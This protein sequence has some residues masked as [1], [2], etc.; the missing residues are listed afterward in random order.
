M[1]DK[2]SAEK[3]LERPLSSDN[4]LTQGGRVEELDHIRRE[5]RRTS[6]NRIESQRLRTPST[7]IIDKYLEPVEYTKLPTSRSIRLLEILPVADGVALPAPQ[8]RV[9]CRMKTVSLDDNPC[10]TALSYTSGDPIW[11]GF[12]PS[13][14]EY[15]T[16][17]YQI[18]C[19]GR[20]MKVH[21]NLHD[22]LLQ[23]RVKISSIVRSFKE[24]KDGDKSR[25]M[26]TMLQS[27]RL[28]GA[29]MCHTR[30]WEVNY[31]WIDAICINQ[32]DLS[33]RGVQV[34]IMGDIYRGAQNVLVWLG[35]HDQ[36][37]EE[38]VR[39][40]SWLASIASHKWSSVRPFQ[41]PKCYH[42][43]GI[44]FITQRQWEAYVAFAQRSWFSRTWILQEAVLPLHLVV[45]HGPHGIPWI[46]LVKSFSFLEVSGW[47]D[48]IVNLAFRTAVVGKHNPNTPD[49]M[50]DICGKVP[51]I[52]SLRRREYGTEHGHLIH[53]I[54]RPEGEIDGSLWGLLGAIRWYKAQDPR[55]LVYATLGILNTP[56]KSNIPNYNKNRLR[57]L[58]RSS[59]GDPG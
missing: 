48:N 42:D 14:P 27:L 34:S 20:A 39:V 3:I 40:C 18:D 56:I 29:G 53:K 36:Q 19:D 50:T 57:G 2:T 47:N 15:E 9:R 55:D 54:S 41:H 38:A 59:V 58:C 25:Q 43:L 45:L 12:N 11:R 46:N 16:C 22:V 23:L 7:V 35:P 30:Y 37:T 31:I 17:G 1:Q 24:S 32:Q 6:N 28:F 52:A 44:Q 5:P 51:R 4:S 26:D 13:A 21:K 33:E 10:F 8:E 49:T